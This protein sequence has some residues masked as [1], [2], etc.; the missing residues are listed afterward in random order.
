MGFDELKCALDNFKYDS[1]DKEKN[2]NRLLDAVN[3][4]VTHCK[5]RNEILNNINE[6]LTSRFE[7]EDVYRRICDELYKL[8]KWDRVSIAL[9][10]M[11]KGIVTAFVLSKGY[12]TEIFPERRNYPYRG[13][14]LERI[15]HTGKPIIIDDTSK[16]ELE[17]DKTHLKEGVRSRMAYPLKF[18]GEIIGSINF[19]SRKTNSFSEK[20]F[21]ILAQITPILAIMVEN[22]R[23]FMEATKCHREYRELTKTIDA[24]WI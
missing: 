20:H 22:T 3:G 13:S 15:M 18:R 11:D 16:G 23:L 10:E 17:T 6:V 1:T 7:V 4:C 19:S 14:I 5:L 9:F 8:I 24:P 2:L 12:K 21:E